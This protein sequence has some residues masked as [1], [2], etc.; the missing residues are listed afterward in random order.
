MGC[1][2]IG[3]SGRDGGVMGEF[4]DVNIIVP[5]DDTP[6]IP[7]DAHYDRAYYHPSDR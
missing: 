5:S 1:K 4:C 3:L 2:T 6:R 7:R